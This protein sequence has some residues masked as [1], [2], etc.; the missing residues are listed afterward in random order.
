M[1]YHRKSWL[2]SIGIVMTVNRTANWVQSFIA[3]KQKQKK[4]KSKTNQNTS[5]FCPGRVMSLVTTSGDSDS[6]PLL[7]SICILFS[8]SC[9]AT[10]SWWQIGGPMSV[11]YELIIVL[12]VARGRTDKR[13]SKTRQVVLYWTC[14]LSPKI[15]KSD[16]L[17]QLLCLSVYSPQW[18]V[19]VKGWMTE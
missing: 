2:Q 14:S 7:P 16:W 13:T 15:G 8:A 6:L 19:S 9:L 18:H 17:C 4:T 11:F 12:E 10:V 3:K 5:T 1:K